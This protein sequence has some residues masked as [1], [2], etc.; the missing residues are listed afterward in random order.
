MKPKKALTKTEQAN[1]WKQLLM[2]AKLDGNTALVKKYEAIITKL[3]N[4]KK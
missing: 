3:T 4:D 2:Q 1:Y